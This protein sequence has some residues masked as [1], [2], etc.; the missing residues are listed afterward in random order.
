MA[1]Q[2]IEVYLNDASDPIQ[3]LKE[4]PFKLSLDTLKLPDGDHTLRVVTHYTN[5]GREVKEVPFKVS[6]MPGVLVEG[7]ESGKE[8]SGELDLTVRVSD[9]D[10]P[11]TR[12]RFPALG[13][14]LATAVILLGVWGFFAITPTTNTVLEEVA[15][16]KKAG[17]H[18]AAEDHSSNGTATEAPEVDQALFAQGEGV[19][20]AN[21]AGCHQATGAGLPGAFPPMA[22]NP[23]LSDGKYVAQVVI[24]GLQNKEIVVDGQTYNGVM[25]GFPQLSDEEVAAVATYVRN[26]WGNTFGGV[27]AEEAA[28][29]R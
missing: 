21:C 1:I 10:V 15:A 27:S 9:P 7:L 6:N 4:P 2:R 20:T 11:L 13:A 5:G 22:N 12:E 23:H 25:P 28:S 26:A 18:S 19:Y 3:V 14:V 17:E 24:Q 29:V 8:V 16:P